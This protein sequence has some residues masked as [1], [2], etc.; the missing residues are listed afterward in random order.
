[1]Y[2]CIFHFNIFLH[3]IIQQHTKAKGNP[4]KIQP[5]I[6]RSL[7]NNFKRRGNITFAGKIVCP[8]NGLSKNALIL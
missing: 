1:M 2:Y 4:S 8:S 6:S 3:S 7:K 5:L